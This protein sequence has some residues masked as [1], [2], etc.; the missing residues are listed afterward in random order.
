[1]NEQDKVDGEDKILKREKGVGPSKV[2]ASLHCVGSFL[3]RWLPQ[4]FFPTWS[5]WSS[6]ILL[7]PLLMP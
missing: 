7:P 2:V 4:L 5:S 3:S 6:H 1:M